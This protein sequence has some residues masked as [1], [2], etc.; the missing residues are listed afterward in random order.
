MRLVGA[1]YQGM[2]EQLSP[3]ARLARAAG[4]QSRVHSIE[5]IL[6]F[7]EEKMLQVESCGTK[8]AT[9][10]D[11][12]TPDNFQSNV[13]VSTGDPSSP[14][15]KKHRRNRTTFTTFQLHELER[16]FER[17]HYPDVYS[18]EELALKVNLPEV[19]VQVWFQNRRAKWRRQ[20]KLEVS[21][22]KLQDSS[23]LSF[24]RP[25]G[26]GLGSGGLPLDPWL[27]G[28]ISGPI[29]SPS[30]PLQSLPGFMASQPASY[31]PPPFLTHSLPHLGPV[32]HPPPP[33][34]AY[35]CSGFMDKLS[36]E[37][38]DP[39]NSSIASLRMKAKEH[40]Q[41]IGKTW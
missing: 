41:S 1:Q 25:A 34:P 17:S 35:Q 12:T 5:A 16:A 21:S 15:R 32:C 8:G 14:D 36:L 6:G 29:S 4:P 33:P 10:T 18:R 31:T 26:P 27:T 11:T 38:T 39:R 28:P 13:C 9:K 24:S 20:E 3:S 30:S 2:E 37:E 22:I 40:I 23:I 19:R 7:R